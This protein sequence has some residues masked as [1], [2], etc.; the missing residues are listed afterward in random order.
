M[1]KMTDRLAELIEVRK[2]RVEHRQ[3]EVWRL[4]Q[5]LHEAREALVVA[6]NLLDSATDEKERREGS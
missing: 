5:E 4:E 3:A 2:D 1:E 6:T